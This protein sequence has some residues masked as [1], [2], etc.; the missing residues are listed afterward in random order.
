MYSNIP[1]RELNNIIINIAKRN[2]IHVDVI[3]EIEQ[4]TN[5]INEQNY[6]EMDNKF[7][8]QS[9]GL[10]LGAPSSA[11]LAE[12]YLQSIE[13]DQILQLLIIY[14]FIISVALQS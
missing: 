1:T 3:N 7:Y 13:H 10:A 2:Y 5:L 14:L 12:F 4:L 8:F 9:E 11:L 6:F